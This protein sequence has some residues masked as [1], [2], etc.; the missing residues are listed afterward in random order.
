MGQDITEQNSFLP[1]KSSRV[2]KYSQLTV[3]LSLLTESVQHISKPNEIHKSTSEKLKTH[4]TFGEFSLT[5][6]A[7]Q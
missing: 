7:T 6:K 2:S 5:S 4:R 1:L 3:P